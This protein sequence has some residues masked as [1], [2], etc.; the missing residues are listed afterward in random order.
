MCSRRADGTT[1][2]MFMGHTW[3]NTAQAHGP[4]KEQK[5]VHGI[6]TAGQHA[7]QRAHENETRTRHDET[8]ILA[9]GRLDYLLWES[10][11][12]DLLGHRLFVRVPR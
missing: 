7:K 8:P 11:S 6:G 3:A 12:G 10:P 2:M 1:T 4:A 9:V 5:D